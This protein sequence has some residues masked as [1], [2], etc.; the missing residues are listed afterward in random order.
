MDIRRQFLS[1]ENLPIAQHI[2]RLP[3][4]YTK[5]FLKIINH[6]LTLTVKGF[7][8]KCLAYF[9]HFCSG[10]LN[11]KFFIQN[12]SLESKTLPKKL[13]YLKSNLKLNTTKTKDKLFFKLTGTFTDKKVT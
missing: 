13:E 9:V 11:S 5:I 4:V 8:S 3:P 1:P 7:F 12:I 10:F 6:I 2:F